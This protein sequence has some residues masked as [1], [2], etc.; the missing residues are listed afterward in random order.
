MTDSSP[1]S[2]LQP[3]GWPRPTGYS[4]GILV[5]PGHA[6]VFTGGMVGWDAD[7]AIVPGG[8]VPQFEQALQ[9]VLAVLAVAAA[10]PEHVVR[11]TCY[12][13]DREEYLASQRDLGAAWLR[14]MGRNFPAMSLVQIAALVED[15]ARIEIEATAAVP[16]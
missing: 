11:M 5:P 7:E 3:E 8:L 1:F 6:L 9:N 13:T 4:N 10:G 15:G 2:R 12:V 16:G 14:T